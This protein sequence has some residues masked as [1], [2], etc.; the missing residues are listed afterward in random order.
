MRWIIFVLFI[1]VAHGFGI[2][3]PPSLR[4]TPRGTYSA[5]I[6]YLP[7]LPESSLPRNNGPT[8]LRTKLVNLVKRCFT[9]RKRYT[10]YVLECKHNKYYVGS[11]TNRSRR[12]REHLSERGGS[13]WTRM[14]KPIRLVKEY[15]R[16]HEDYYLGK[17]AQVTAELMLQYG[18]NN[19][20]GAMFSEPRSYTLQD[21]NALTG[22]L[23]HYN[24]LDYKELGVRLEM[25]LNRPARRRRKKAKKSDRCYRCG[26]TGH[27]AYK[28][29]KGS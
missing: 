28:C 16:I 5:R 20:R 6:R 19:V 8:R 12:I 9:R 24:N 23:G 10:V 18:I 29:P 22:F 14:H 7:L 21:A 25:E 15:R 3:S 2:W 17:E 4:T 26:Q 1:V 27:W 11:T 13:K